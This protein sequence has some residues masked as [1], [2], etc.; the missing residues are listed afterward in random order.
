MK[1]SGTGPGCWALGAMAGLALATV[2]PGSAAADCRLALAVGLDRSASVD[3]DELRLMVEGT[4]R[5]L[6]DD[7]VRAAFLDLPAHPVDL[8]IFEWSGIGYQRLILD[9]TTVRSDAALDD[10]A[11]A[12]RARL[13]PPAPGA[14]PADVPPSETAIGSAMLYAATLL[15]RR[16]GCWRRVLDLAGDGRSNAGPLPDAVP[17][18]PGGGPA[19]VNAL[20]IGIPEGRGGDPGLAELTS[21]FRAH[22]LRGP[23]AFL[24][25]A[26]GFGDVREAM[27]RKL[28]RE[29][30]VTVGT[31]DTPRLPGRR[32][33]R[34]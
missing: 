10:A 26:E 24:Q 4:A 19:T 28:L 15:E 27:V 23:G 17:F 11:E 6:E 18:A 34:G 9:W 22:V 12:L 30:A 8:A 13:R 21:Y 31:G 1:A 20:V 3:A 5:A 14:A 2:S 16:S 32:K 33:G 29:L 7:A 25:G